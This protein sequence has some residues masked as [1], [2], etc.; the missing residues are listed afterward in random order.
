MQ[1]VPATPPT[2][3]LELGTLAPP[4]ARQALAGFFVS[5]ML[6]AFLGAILPSW[7]HHLLSDYL[8]VGLYFVA[9]IAGMIASAWAAPPLMAG[10]GLGW[11]LAFA[12]GMAS[13]ALL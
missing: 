10:K 13:F 7:Q 1:A 3:T 8:M 4:G 12:C 9:L 2:A 11:T 5:G 6:L